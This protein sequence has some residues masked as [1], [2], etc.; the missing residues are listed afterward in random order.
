MHGK[1]RPILDRF[2]PISTNDV[3]MGKQEGAAAAAMVARR[4]IRTLLE[5]IVAELPVLWE[6]EVC[7]FEARVYERGDEWWGSRTGC[8]ERRVP[9]GWLGRACGRGAVKMLSD[10]V[11][12]VGIGRV[13]STA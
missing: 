4:P 2:A 10:G 9:W 13:L 1:T 6:C 3:V 11:C 8:F 12:L 7:V 5:W